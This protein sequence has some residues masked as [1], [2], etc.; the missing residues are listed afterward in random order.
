M[1]AENFWLTLHC[2]LTDLAPEGPGWYIYAAREGAPLIPLR[3]LTREQASK[4][5]RAFDTVVG[6]G[7]EAPVAPWQLMQSGDQLIRQAIDTQLEEAEA[8]AK[9]VAK[10][11][12]LQ[13]EAAD[14]REE[15]ESSNS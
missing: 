5:A 14:E 13:A 1:P 15:E 8:I 7:A 3:R 6:E 4:I 9:K 12:R 11:R 10:L 2:D